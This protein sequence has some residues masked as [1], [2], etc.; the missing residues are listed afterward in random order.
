VTV[1]KKYHFDDAF[2]HLIN[3]TIAQIPSIIPNGQ[4]PC[5]KP[6]IDPKT[7]AKENPKINQ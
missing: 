5:K 1:I 6:Y 2:I 3:A 7:Q 4:A